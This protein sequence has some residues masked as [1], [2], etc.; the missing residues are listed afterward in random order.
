VQRAFAYSTPHHPYLPDAFGV[1]LYPAHE[2]HG[3]D[4]L[5]LPEGVNDG[6]QAVSVSAQHPAPAPAHV[7]QAGRPALKTRGKTKRVRV[8]E[9][10]LEQRP[11]PDEAPLSEQFRWDAAWAAAHFIR[12]VYGWTEPKEQT[13]ADYQDICSYMLARMSDD[14]ALFDEFCRYLAHDERYFRDR[15]HPKYAGF[16][17]HKSP[18]HMHDEF[19][20][21]QKQQPRPKRRS[22]ASYQNLHN[23]G[24]DG[25]LGC[26]YSEEPRARGDARKPGQAHRADCLYG[27][28]GPVGKD[29]WRTSSLVEALRKQEENQ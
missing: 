26:L 7:Q 18:R 3:P 24:Y 27:R 17:W 16:Y 4:H 12:V 15:S 1:S 9:L 20:W 10:G 23:A 13:V 28:P 29:D 22:T 21:W 25:C 5:H 11:D 8:R 6:R 14:C 19:Y 2:I